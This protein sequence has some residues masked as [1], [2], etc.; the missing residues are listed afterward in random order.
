[1]V[2]PTKEQELYSFMNYSFFPPWKV[3]ETTDGLSEEI[4]CYF[5]GGNNR[6]KEGGENIKTNIPIQS[7]A[8]LKTEKPEKPEKEMV[9]D[10]RYW[11][12][13]S[14]WISFHG[15]AEYDLISEE[16]R[17]TVWR[18]EKTKMSDW[19]Q[20]NFLV[21]KKEISK[22][23][24]KMTNMDMEDAIT[25]LVTDADEQ[26][27]GLKTLLLCWTYYSMTMEDKGAVE[28]IWVVPAK[29]LY[30]SFS[31]GLVSSDSSSSSSVV[32]WG[33]FMEILEPNEGKKNK[34]GVEGAPPRKP[35]KKQKRFQFRELEKG[36]V[37]SIRSSM[38]EFKAVNRPLAAISKYTL[39]ELMDTGAK[40]GL[41]PPMISVV[42]EKGAMKLDLAEKV[43][44]AELE[45]GVV[46]KS[47]EKKVLK[48]ELDKV[49]KWKKGDWYERMEEYCLTVF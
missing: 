11:A 44:S 14:A 4:S 25:G 23:W 3:M 32:S 40:M 45:L 16:K 39:K 27:S 19:F 1:M 26:E 24:D 28:C 42:D 2:M 20:V 47:D 9:I 48:K 31:H 36:A 49:E 34:K 43:R 7:I 21:A 17:L 35:L 13:W 37:E 22:R 41:S 30:Y 10:W 33:V 12:F 38:V 5:M 46:R 15:L 6:K 8:P 18:E 29:S